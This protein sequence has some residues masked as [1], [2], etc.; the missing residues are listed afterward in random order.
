MSAESLNTKK[1]RA[2]NVLKAM[3]HPV[4][5][6]IV[7]ILEEKTKLNVTQIY[8]A[9]KIEQAVASHHLTILKDRGVLVAERRGKHTLYQLKN[10]LLGEIVNQ[11]YQCA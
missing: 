8:T 4:R 6:Q 5:M 3:A 1:L 10:H 9:L 7:E 11:A 2:A